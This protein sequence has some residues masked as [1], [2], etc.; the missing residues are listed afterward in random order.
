MTFH[1]RAK[2]L[3]NVWSYDFY[4]N[5]L[6]TEQQRRHMIKKLY[7]IYHHKSGILVSISFRRRDI[8]IISRPPSCYYTNGGS[9]IRSSLVD[10]LSMFDCNFDNFSIY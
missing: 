9:D 6:P 7:K 8:A 5:T 2:M 4:D 3:C 10:L 1:V